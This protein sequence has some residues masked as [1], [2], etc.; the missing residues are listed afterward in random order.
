MTGSA[1][2]E[3]WLKQARKAH[4]LTQKELARRIGCSVRLIEK[5]ERGERRPSRQMAEL[6]AGSLGVPHE[7]RAMFMLFARAPGTDTATGI[8]ASASYAPWRTEPRDPDRLPAFRSTF[9]GREPQLQ[10]LFDLIRGYTARLITITGAPGIGKTRLALEVM[11]KIR[12]TFTDG[13]HFVPLDE[14]REPNELLSFLASSL[15]L[16]VTADTPL[17]NAVRNHLAG[18]HLLLVLDN[19]EHLIP[20]ADMLS[21]LRDG[22]PRVTV[23]VT[24]RERLQLSIEHELRLEPL[25]LPGENRTAQS[26]DG[27]SDSARLAHIAASE[28]VRLFVHR[29]EMVSPG[30]TLKS[31]NARPIG[32]ICRRLDGLPLAIELAASRVRALSP[33]AIL[34]KLDCSLSLLTRGPRDLPPRLQTLRTAID[35]SY[36]LLDEHEKAL[37][38]QLSIF[39]HGFTLDAAEAVNA[40]RREKRA[41]LQVL[42]L[43]EALINKSLVQGG[44][45]EGSASRFSML[46]PLREY[47][48]ELL[49]ECGGEEEARHRHACFYLELAEH[50]HDI[51]RASDEPAWLSLLERE[52]ENLRAALAWAWASDRQDLAVRLVNSLWEFWLRRGYWHEGQ[53]QVELAL[54]SA[55]LAEP[56]K[57]KAKAMLGA[58]FLSYARGELGRSVNV[59]KTCIEI[60]RKLGDTK[61]LGISLNVLGLVELARGDKRNEGEHHEEELAIFQ[62]EDSLPE[63]ASALC[64]QSLQCLDAGDLISAR[65]K[66]EESIVISRRSGDQIR[67]GHA[68]YA[69][70]LVQLDEAQYAQA[71]LHGEEALEIFQSLRSV[72]GTAFMLQCLGFAEAGEDNLYRAIELFKQST[73]AFSELGQTQSIAVS[74][75]GL[76]RVALMQDRPVQAARLFGAALGTLEGIGY[77]AVPTKRIR[78]DPAM[79]DTRVKLGQAKFDREFTRGRVMNVEEVRAYVSDWECMKEG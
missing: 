42:D 26:G 29:A 51:V 61:T 53:Q 2:I 1:T 19:F 48:L 75:A 37:F 22:C 67:I 24:S 62:T 71:K 54:Q 12:S 73:A 36:A 31:E 64:A 72:R 55:V 39:P 30:F 45:I 66:A 40:A 50:A 6:L 77:P 56:S 41:Q 35:G 79:E 32:E 3:G 15:R 74:L 10:A 9:V 33:V 7:H 68:L 14:V 65:R 27:T 59:L 28:A 11:R 18:K 5:I 25:S 21:T 13:A 49:R 60:A 70:V 47:G 4:D 8:T 38:R 34:E 52:H 63:L 23:L 44:A 20:A 58:G 46:G 69:L 57:Q 78:R 43:L 17:S 76:G 16:H